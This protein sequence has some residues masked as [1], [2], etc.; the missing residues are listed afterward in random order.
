MGKVE[1]YRIN[2]QISII[3]LYSTKECSENK[4]KRTISFTISTKKFFKINF[5]KEVQNYTAVVSHSSPL[6]L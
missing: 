5:T 3:F 4:I 2:G 6:T 1:E